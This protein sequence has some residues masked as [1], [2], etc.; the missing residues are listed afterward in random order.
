LWGQKIEAGPAGIEAMSDP[1]GLP[2]AGS[3][4]QPASP[5]GLRRADRAGATSAAIQVTEHL[6]AHGGVRVQGRYRT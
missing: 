2:P 1:G 5:V 4:A 6:A 3:D